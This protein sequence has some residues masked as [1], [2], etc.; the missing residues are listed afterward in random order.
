MVCVKK[1]MAL[2][3]HLEA[4]ATFKIEQ[5]VL[6]LVLTE[7]LFVVK[8]FYYLSYTCRCR[9]HPAYKGNQLVAATSSLI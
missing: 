1:K 2:I 5:E 8:G 7:S 4:F 3:L 6:A 9:P